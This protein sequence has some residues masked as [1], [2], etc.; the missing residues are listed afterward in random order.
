MPQSLMNDIMPETILRV[1]GI[2]ELKNDLYDNNN[3]KISM[4][5]L[6]EIHPVI[7]GNK[8][9]KLYYFLKEAEVSSHKKIITF[10][11]AFSNHLAA[12][13][14]ACKEMNL[15]CIGIVRGEKP[16]T[17]S[18]TL[19]FCME[20]GMQLQFISRASYQKINE[21]EF[22]EE[23]KN[24]YGESILIPEGGFSIKG[25]KGA[26]LITQFFGDK[27][28]THVCLP[29]GT[30]TTFAGII[31][32]NE[33][34]SKIIGFGVLKNFQDIEKRFHELE[35]NPEREYSF[36]GDYH[37]GGYAKKTDELISFINKFY[38]EHK[39]PLDFV[40]TGKMMFGVNDLV[41]KK[42]FLEGADILCIHTGGLQGN[43]SL[44][45]LQRRV[46]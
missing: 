12:T 16:V 24:K 36:I 6:D 1:P 38:D 21:K 8:L 17:L 29:V 13:A 26:E 18:H 27:K 43:E 20:N 23:L 19:L 10:G 22:L 35:V 37:F 44:P 31:D 28:F 32:I 40:Y 30:A 4:L 5:R 39:I 42:Y 15:E 2:N 3:I 34:D 25:K 9:F 41:R 7:S 46:L 11:G 14:F 45:V 33:N